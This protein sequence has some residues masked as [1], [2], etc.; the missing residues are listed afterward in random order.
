MKKCQFAGMKY[1]PSTD[2]YHITVKTQFLVRIFRI[3]SVALKSLIL[4]R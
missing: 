3:R 2:Q 4:C 1:F